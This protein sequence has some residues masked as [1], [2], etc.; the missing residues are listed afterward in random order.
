MYLFL[1]KILEKMNNGNLLDHG[2]ATGLA[3][4]PWLKNDWNCYGIDPHK[5]SVKHAKNQGLN[6]KY[7]YGEKLPYKS[8]FFEVILKLVYF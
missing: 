4:L 1:N 7:G 5:P 3:L 2:T 6:V 8:Y